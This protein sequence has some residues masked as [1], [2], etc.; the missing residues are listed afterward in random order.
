MTQAGRDAL[1]HGLGRLKAGQRLDV[2][3][4]PSLAWTIRRQLLL[5]EFELAA[6]AALREVEIRVRTLGG[7]GDE[8]LG[9]A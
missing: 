2:D 1:Q 5:G 7:F 4:H 3:L 6:F 8:P 9:V